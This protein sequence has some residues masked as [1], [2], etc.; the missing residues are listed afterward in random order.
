MSYFILNHG[1]GKAVGGTVIPDPTYVPQNGHDVTDVDL[2]YEEKGEWKPIPF[3]HIKD[4]GQ[5]EWEYSPKRYI[6]G[7][8][9]GKIAA[10]IFTPD[11]WPIP[12]RVSQIGGISMRIEGREI[13]NECVRAERVV[14]MVVQPFQWAEVEEFAIH[15]QQEGIRLLP[16]FL[17][18]A[19]QLWE[20]L[21]VTQ[22]TDNRSR[23]E[24][25]SLE[26]EVLAQAANIPT[27][28]DGRLQAHSGGF[29][30]KTCPVFGVIK[31]HQ[32]IPLDMS[33]LKVLYGLQ[34]GERLPAFVHAPVK[35]LTTLT[36]YL[37]IGEGGG[38]SALDGVVRIEV[39]LDWYESHAKYTNFIDRL[40][41]VVMAYRCQRKSYN[42]A[43]ITLEPI[44]RGED[45]LSAVFGNY[46]RLLNHFYYL[47]HIS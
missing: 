3:L 10:R 13:L 28:V 29:D 5:D 40:S 7:K 12:V 16:V 4:W 1:G 11:G 2:S 19:T 30:S 18:P 17:D 6:D 47:A 37:K 43:Q 9:V 45:R 25:F 33:R 23:E 46:T 41:R 20:S 31:T 32:Q 26:E 44:V 15:L 21:A 36:W 24:M 42:R 39:S 22:A 34:L 27:I 14:T 8:D 38:Q 35:N